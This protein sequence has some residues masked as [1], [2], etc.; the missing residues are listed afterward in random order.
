MELHFSHR[1]LS[2][3]NGGSQLQNVVAPTSF[4]IPLLMHMCIYV[5]AIQSLTTIRCY[6]TGT[7]LCNDFALCLILFS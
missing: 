7:P 2:S 6:D 3:H 5:S 1:G 4:Y